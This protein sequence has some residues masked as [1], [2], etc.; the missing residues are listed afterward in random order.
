MPQ[1]FPDAEQ[2]AEAR[3]IL[4]NGHYGDLDQAMGT[5]TLPRPYES[6]IRAMIAEFGVLTSALGLR[7][8]DSSG[9]VVLV[10]VTVNST[11]HTTPVLVDVEHGE[12]S[13]TSHPELGSGAIPDDVL[14]SNIELASAIREE[15][16]GVL[17]TWRNSEGDTDFT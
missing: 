16:L 13:F 15:L 10:P 6:D 4:A 3:R 2:V 14:Q 17:A 8:A 9:F 11:S 1:F 12:L 5:P 7:D